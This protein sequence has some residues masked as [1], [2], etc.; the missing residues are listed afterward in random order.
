MPPSNA[1]ASAIAECNSK[2]G[3]IFHKIQMSVSGTKLPHII[4]EK[5]TADSYYL[6]CCIKSGGTSRDL[7]ECILSRQQ[8]IFM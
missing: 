7:Q 6:P 3:N 2:S 1:I 5:E 4:E 8:S